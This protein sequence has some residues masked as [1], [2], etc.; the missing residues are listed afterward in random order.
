MI[1]LRVKAPLSFKFSF[2]KILQIDNGNPLGII[3]RNKLVTKCSE[4]V[5]IH[6]LFSG[7]RLK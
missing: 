7:E 1:C 6:F 2:H 3:C 5:D 4:S